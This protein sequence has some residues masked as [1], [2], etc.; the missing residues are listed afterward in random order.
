MTSFRPVP[1]PRRSRAART[2]I[3]IAVLLG[4]A[5]LAWLW[6][7]PPYPAAD[8]DRVA[9]RLKAEAGQTYD[10]GTHARPAGT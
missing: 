5:A 8:P 6:N 1:P 10:A 9:V 7:G 2:A 4:V 3:G